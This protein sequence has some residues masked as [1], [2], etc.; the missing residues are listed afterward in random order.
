MALTTVWPL[1]LVC[2]IGPLLAS[3]DFGSVD[4]ATRDALNL[5][6]FFCVA[7]P[8]IVSR[9]SKAAASPLLRRVELSGDLTPIYRLANA[10]ANHAEKL[11]GVRLD[12]TTLSAILDE[13]VWRDQ[14]AKH[15]EDVGRWRSSAG[16][17]T[18]LFAPASH[19]WKTMA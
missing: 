19:V 9:R 5:L 8:C 6:L 14:V 13:S 7:T 15:I 11:Q 2:R 18:F 4:Q 12:V 16:A 17:A 10:V 1:S 3:L